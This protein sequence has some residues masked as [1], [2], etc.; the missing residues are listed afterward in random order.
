[1]TAFL[2][3]VSKILPIIDSTTAIVE[4][5]ITWIEFLNYFFF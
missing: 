5:I 4:K 3:V 2:K 1:M